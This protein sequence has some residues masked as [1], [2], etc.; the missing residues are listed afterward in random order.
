[1]VEKKRKTTKRF[2]T[3]FALPLVASVIIILILMGTSMLSLGQ[4]ARVRS[5]RTT[6]DIAARIAADAGLVKA[7]F[8]MNRKVES[9][10]VWNNDDLPLLENFKLPNSSE[11]YNF[12]V[13]GDPSTGFSIVSTG[14]SGL[15]ERK[16]YSSI[17]LASIYDFGIAVK[18]D[19]ILYPNSAVTAY[20]SDTGETNLWT[21]IGTNSIGDDSVLVMN[22][23]TVAGDVVVGL[24]GD[25]SVVIQNRGEIEGGT[26]AMPTEYYFPPVYPPAGLAYRGFIKNN[27]TIGP[28]NSGE[29]SYIALGNSEV[30]TVDGGHVV[31]H[32]TGDIGMRNGAE[33]L[34]NAGSS[35]E[36]YIDG[37]WESKEG[38]GINNLNGIPSNMS[39][40]GTGELGQSIDIKANNE[41]YATVYAPNA[42][43][44]VKAGGDMY[45]S[46]IVHDF[47]MKSKST[48]N[49]DK[50]L[51]KNKT[52]DDFGVYFTVSSW[53]EE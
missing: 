47:E 26:W 31:M 33:I 6:S 28:A 7:I 10:A 52:I 22:N 51:S 4:H 49:H 21:T 53:R 44:G 15:A 34:I 29:Y 9:E 27:V 30:I 35:L 41:L 14:Y 50:A 24:G 40:Y 45:G 20:D 32:I 43:V 25:P 39:I 18:A 42:Q 12:N 3:G 16:V 11:T 46:F 8:L 48:M 36:L 38:S 37:N 13:E 1:M 23:A 5:L 19:L 2:R 17:R